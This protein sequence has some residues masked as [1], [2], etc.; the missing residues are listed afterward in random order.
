VKEREILAIIQC[1][2]DWSFWG[3]MNYVMAKP[4]SGSVR[5][6]LV[7]DEEQG[8]LTEHSGISSKGYL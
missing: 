5:H 6:V 2:K 4:C 1:K 3:Q 7:E 8:T